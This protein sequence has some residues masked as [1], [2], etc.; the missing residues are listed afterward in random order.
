MLLSVNQLKTRL[1]VSRDLAYSLVHAKGF[2][3]IKIG[4]RYYVSEEALKKWLSKNEG[5]EIIL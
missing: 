5:R 4:G 1:N 3:A 2:P